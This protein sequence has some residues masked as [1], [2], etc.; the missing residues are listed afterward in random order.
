MIAIR[1][2]LDTRRQTRQPFPCRRSAS[3]LNFANNV[4]RRSKDCGK[5]IRQRSQNAG[6]KAPVTSATLDDRPLLRSFELFVELREVTRESG[7]KQLAAL[8]TRAIVAFPAP[9]LAIRSL[10][11]TA[12][13]IVERRLHPIVKSDSGLHVELILLIVRLA[14]PA[15]RDSYSYRSVRSSFSSKRV[16]FSVTLGGFTNSAVFGRGRQ[17]GLRTRRRWR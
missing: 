17:A 14:K 6:R 4:S 2:K 7:R 16:V 9:T 5:L 1:T 8:R 11:I 13:R 12:G 3:S 15:S 10:I